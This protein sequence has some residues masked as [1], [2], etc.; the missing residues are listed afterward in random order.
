[1][2]SVA[3]FPTVI[4]SASGFPALPIDVVLPALRA[5]LA[6]S[7]NVVLQAP[8]GAGKTTGVPLALLDETWLIGQRILI[9]EPRRLAARAAARRMA[10]TRR[11]SVGETVGFRVR[12]D[13]RVGPRTRIEVVTEGILT[14]MLHRDAAL[15]GVGLLVFDEFHERSLHADLGLALALESQS[16]LRPELRIL[17]M[18]A[19]L[20]G[21]RVSTLLDDA[22]V[23]ASEGRAYPVAVQYRPRR[24]DQYL[25][26]ATASTIRHVL[27]AHD[28]DVLVF[29]PGAG[30]IRSTMQRLAE[31]ALPIGVSVLPLFGALSAEAQDVALTPSPPLER[32]VVLATSIAQTSLTIE[33]VQVVVDAG[34]SRVP[35]FSPRSG[36]SRLQTVRVSRDSSEQRC[37]RAGRTGPGFCYRLWA[38]EEQHGLLE[39]DRPEILDADL[40]P[41]ALDLALAGITDASTLRWL[42]P[43]P[44]PALAHARELLVQL[45]AL[46]EHGRITVHGRAMARLATHPRLAHMLLRGRELGM[47]ATACVVAALLDERDVL[48]GNGSASDADLRT[49]IGLVAADNARH[50]TAIDRDV[51]RRVREQ[52]HAW[53]T[54]LGAER[55]DMA[56][57][58]DG[59][60][61][62]ALAFPDRV[63][64]RRR[65]AGERYLLRSGVGG[66]LAAG[67]SLTGAPFLAVAELDGQRPHARI[68]LAAPIERAE[69]DRLFADQ[70]E[71]DELVSW[72]D[73]SGVIAV[74]RRERLG[75]IVLRETSVLD[76]DD[77][78][79]ADA[80]LG[81]LTRGVSLR[82]RWSVEAQRTRERLA[83]LHAKLEDWPDVGEAGLLESAR[84][85][86]LPHLAGLRRRS[87]IDELDLS[88]LLLARLNWQQRARLDELAPTHFEVPSGS[89][90]RVDYRDP[91]TPVLA[92]RLQELFGL[93]AT[94]FVGGS[95]VPLTL[96]LLSP[97][98]RPV[99]ITRDLAGFWRG[100][101]FDVRKE[102]RGRYPKHEWPDDPSHAT[103]TT[104]AKRR[105]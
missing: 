19:T 94:P 66:S 93:E 34:F 13:S 38:A 101:Y 11:E 87:Q 95:N 52:N 46:A 47:T 58:S 92:V 81:E 97:A 48:R 35:S 89:R 67:A 4:A 73:T 30:E 65:G 76:A 61:V 23:V 14:R 72:N 88:A 84:E 10:A 7:P 6:R 86:L 103:P 49:R 22:P 17:V 79:V 80:L 82:M 31:Q 27:S 90:I 36:M 68:L 53:R 62:L 78:I 9:L 105:R 100:S 54:E 25:D 18:S 32:K 96:H 29:L 70:V 33:G 24:A 74:L 63:A 44:A 26:V 37:G 45:G 16:V 1:M 71:R 83:F 85:W 91:S 21:A 41:L 98:Y 2:D 57:E 75:A 64:Q 69:L 12:G 8:P 42:D 28:G 15:E 102:L 56:V 55:A 99:Q 51:L 39:H 60:V 43:P 3:S 59:G 40:A 5:A 50:G 77:S 104:R 20:D